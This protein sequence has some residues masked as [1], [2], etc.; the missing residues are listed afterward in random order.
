M[1]EYE[2]RGYTIIENSDGYFEVADLEFPSI[3]EAMDWV[4]EQEDYIPEPNPSELH[5]YVFFYIDQATDMSFEVMIEAA[6][7]KNAEK[8]L[9]R[10]YDV[11][12][13]ADWYRVD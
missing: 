13:I 12:S 4:D 3:D 6:N 5:K 2:Y 1:E 7:Y 10:E 9:R 8:K 11:Y